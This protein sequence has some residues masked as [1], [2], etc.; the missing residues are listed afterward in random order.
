MTVVVDDDGGRSVEKSLGL[1]TS[2]KA[3]FPFFF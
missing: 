2:Q 3:F 1:N